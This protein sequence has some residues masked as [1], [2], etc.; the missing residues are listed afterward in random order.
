MTD[1]PTTTT[2]ILALLR[3]KRF[4]ELIGQFESSSLE[5]KSKP[6]DFSRDSSKAELA[7]DV[8]GFANAGGG[9]LLLGYKAETK[10]H[11]AEDEVVDFRPIPVAKVDI[12]Q[13]RSILH[14]WLYPSSSSAEVHLFD[15]DL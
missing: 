10:E 12:G 6:Y 7:K 15:A 2:E 5:C 11:Y 1:L 14:A 4:L 9:L 13:I 8:S 3:E